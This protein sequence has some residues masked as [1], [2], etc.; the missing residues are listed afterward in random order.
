M[1]LRRFHVT[2]FQTSFMSDPGI[3]RG[4]LTERWPEKLCLEG[5]RSPGQVPKT[6]W[7]LLPSTKRE[8]VT[9]KR[10]RATAIG[11]PHF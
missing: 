8:A 4:T 7:E 10:A 11:M 5:N 6:M 2:C 3:M 1:A 9:G